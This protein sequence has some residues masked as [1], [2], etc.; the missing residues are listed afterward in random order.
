MEEFSVKNCLHFVSACKS[1]PCYKEQADTIV[2]RLI[3]IKQTYEESSALA[4]MVDRLA[5]DIDLRSTN[6]RSFI[7]MKTPAKQQTQT[8]CFESIRRQS[9][10][11]DINDIPLSI[12]VEST[13]SNASAFI[14]KSK[15][16]EVKAESSMPRAKRIRTKPKAKSAKKDIL[17]MTIK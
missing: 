16:K 3:D 17:N 5:T 4:T 14:E 9:Y 11:S 13:F 15:K 1:I 6:I 10:E 12:D 2:A 7:K 8:K